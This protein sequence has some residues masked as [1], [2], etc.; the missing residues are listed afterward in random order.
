MG[1]RL[2]ELREMRGLSVAQMIERLGVKDSRFRKWESESAAM[3]LEYAVKACSVLHCS[4]DELAGREKIST[5]TPYADPRQARLN[6]LW[7]ELSDA[8]KTHLLHAAESEAALER[9]RPRT[10]TDL[11]GVRRTA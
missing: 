8:G 4:L 7:T 6:R 11:G 2:R 9:E 5:V 1:I 10:Q 3:P